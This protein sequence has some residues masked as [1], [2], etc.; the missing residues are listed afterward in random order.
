MEEKG[1]KKKKEAVLQRK[2]KEGSFP[3][4]SADRTG[5]FKDQTVEVC[6]SRRLVGVLV[7]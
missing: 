5:M 2:L 7:G 1:K 3:R 6:L 4:W